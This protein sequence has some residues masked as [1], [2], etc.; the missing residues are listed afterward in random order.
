V[1]GKATGGRVRAPLVRERAEKGD[2]RG[3]DGGRF[4]DC[5]VPGREKFSK[6]QGERCAGKG[7]TAREGRGNP[8]KFLPAKEIKV[9]WNVAFP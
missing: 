7:A 9:G 8:R 5:L 6:M 4:E 1:R 2:G 3:K